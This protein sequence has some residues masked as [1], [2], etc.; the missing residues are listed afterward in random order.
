MYARSDLCKFL[1][2]AMDGRFSHFTP[3]SLDRA[4]AK[5]SLQAIEHDG[6]LAAVMMVQGNE[7]HVA[8][9]PKMRARW[10]SRGKIRTILGPL[11]ER[12]GMLR[13]KVADGNERGQAFVRRLGF[14][15]VG[16]EYILKEL[17]HA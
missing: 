16:S 12:H 7:I 10:L 17:A 11:L 1:I 4:T 6:K 3:A 9:D 14:E 13:T 2:G 5:W 8:A 15:M